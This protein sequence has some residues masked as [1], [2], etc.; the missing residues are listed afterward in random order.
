MTNDEENI[1]L[2]EPYWPQSSGAILITSRSWVNFNFDPERK[3]ATVELFNGFERL[4]VLYRLLDWDATTVDEK[5]SKDDLET[6]KT[7]LLEKQGFGLGLAIQLTSSLIRAHRSR[8]APLQD[9]LETYQRHSRNIPD[10]PP[11]DKMLNTS[12]VVDVLYS[13][14]FAALSPHARTLLNVL[15]LL[16]PDVTQ[17]AIFNPKNQDVLSPMLDFCKQDVRRLATLAPELQVVVR[18]LRDA[19]LVKREARILSIHRVVQEAFFYL[20]IDERQ[21]AFDAAVRL[22]DEAFPKQI[23]GRPL[24]SAWERCETYIQEALFLAG[25]FEDFLKQGQPL[26]AVPEFSELLKNAAWYLFEVGEHRE[27]K[28]LL[29]TA[30]SVCKDEESL[31][32]AHL[33]NTAGVVDFELNHLPMCRQSLEKALEVRRKLLE[34]DHEELA[35]TINNMGNLVSAEGNPEEAMKYFRDAKEIRQRLGEDSAVP[36]AVTY[37]CTGRALVLQGKFDD[38]MEQYEKAESLAVQYAGINTV[39]AAR[40]NLERAFEIGDFRRTGLDDGNLARILWRQAAIMSESPFDP[41]FQP[42]DIADKRSQARI[43][44]QAVEKNIQAKIDAHDSDDVAYDKLLCG[45]FR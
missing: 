29:K 24:H 42:R 23:H 39:V 5:I 28:L 1:N 10:R 27:S 8:E 6:I 44:R 19:A 45:Y 30:F 31:L 20:H 9:L 17:E 32:Y 33:C 36:L 7:L 37:Q 26:T 35:N 38:A 21:S 41:S 40:R 13:I 2:L 12:H 4:E 11:H 43:M 18:E 16:S 22:I 15:C 3:G 14:A 25:K 34:P